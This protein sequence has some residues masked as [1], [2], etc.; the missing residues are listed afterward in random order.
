MTQATI[1]VMSVGLA[2]LRWGRRYAGIYLVLAL[3]VLAPPS[4]R[5]V[6]APVGWL[7]GQRVP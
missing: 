4:E 6:A 3:G 5:W 2:R 7:D 1:A